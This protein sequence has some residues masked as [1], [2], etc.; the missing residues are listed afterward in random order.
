MKLETKV[1]AFFVASVGVLGLLILRMEKLEVFG[2]NS[3]A[4]IATNFDQVAG[5]S[6]QSA[7]RVAGVKVGAV[8]AIELEGKRARVILTLPKDFKVYKDA[9]AS[10]SSIGILGE[11]YIELDPGHPEAGEVGQDGLIASRQGMSMDSLMESLGGISK[12]VKGITEALNKSIGGEEGRQKLDEIVDNIRVLTAEFRSMAQ[13]NHGAINSTMANVQQ[14]SADLRD[15]LPKLAQQFEDLG[16]NLNQLVGENKPEVQGLLQDV[17]KLTANLQN[18]AE[19]VRSITDKMNKGEGT[20]GKL[21]NDDS[22]VK[23][24]NLAVDNV[25]SM[26]GGFRA[27]ELNLDLNGA[28]WTKRGDSKVGLGIDIVPSHDHWYSL[29]LSSTPDGKISQYTSTVGKI[30]T[31]T[32]AVVQVPVTTNTVNVDQ[33]FTISAQF[34]KRLAENF[35]FTAGIVEGKGGAG[36]EFRAKDDRFRFGALAY[37]FSKRADKPNPRYRITTSYQFYKGFYAMAGL[38]DLANAD[39]RT[40]F[41]GGGLRWKDEDLKK[42]VGLASVGK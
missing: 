18:T 16:R 3:N 14:M 10:L 33:T 24:L 22:T 31:A 39:L 9:T 35:V 13:E 29:E 12:D 34:A 27:M 30:D 21:L 32:G 2:G 40:F 23:K 8:T 6:L 4:R 11:K 17:R 19:N 37:D 28:R 38:Q 1:G 5:L 25:N 7:V 36:A 15:R 41:F 26:L 42:L 20:I